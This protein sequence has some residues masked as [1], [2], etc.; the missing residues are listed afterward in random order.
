M[1]SQERA[2]PAGGFNPLVDAPEVTEDEQSEA[3]EEQQ[4]IE[5]IFLAIFSS[6]QGKIA[7]AYL[8]SRTENTPGFMAEMGLWNG[9]A[10]GFVR[11]GQNSIIRHID[12]LMHNALESKTHE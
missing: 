10:W 11:E 7:L 3:F 1:A 12:E 5:N 6:S 8:R 2:I 4:K 9:I